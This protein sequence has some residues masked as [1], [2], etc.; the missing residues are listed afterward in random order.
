LTDNHDAA[1]KVGGE[2][3]C[4]FRF[5]AAAH[6]AIIVAVAHNFLFVLKSGSNTSNDGS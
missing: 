6:R 1:A 4:A 5:L 2:G 3:G